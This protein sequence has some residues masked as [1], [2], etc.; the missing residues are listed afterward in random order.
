MGDLASPYQPRDRVVG[1]RRRQQQTP[2]PEQEAAT[3]DHGQGSDAGRP[4][5]LVRMREGAPAR[6]HAA[7]RRVDCDWR[8]QLRGSAVTATRERRRIR[9]RWG[10]SPIP[11]PTPRCSP[12]R[13]IGVNATPTHRKQIQQPATW[14]PGRL[15]QRS[16]PR[17]AACPRCRR[18]FTSRW[19]CFGGVA[20]RQ[21][22]VVVARSATSVPG[23][24][25]CPAS[26]HCARTRTS[27]SAGSS[28]THW[29]FRARPRP[30]RS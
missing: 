12:S 13:A 27:S 15:T 18:S 26:G 24:T 10:E 30:P 6:K 23:R 17:R 11:R 9:D 19:S 1:R 21:L 22:V 16:S 25:C 8:A 4:M 29:A 7:E 2:E 14:T 20:P 5:P 28:G 3:D